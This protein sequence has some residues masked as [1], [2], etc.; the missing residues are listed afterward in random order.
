MTRTLQAFL[1]SLQDF[2]NFFHYLAHLT[3]APPAPFRVPAALPGGGILKS[4]ILG[5]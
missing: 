2:E 1:L 5:P 3:I 4:I